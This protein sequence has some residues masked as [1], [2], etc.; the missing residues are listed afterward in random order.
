MQER[1]LRLEALI[2]IK[3]ARAGTIITSPRGLL[4]VKDWNV[5]DVTSRVRAAKEKRDA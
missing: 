4:V 2:K 1:L 5:N 3:R